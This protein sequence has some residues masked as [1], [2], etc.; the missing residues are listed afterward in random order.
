M[1]SQEGIIRAFEIIILIIRFF[2]LPEAHSI[3]DI[4]LKAKLIPNTAPTQANKVEVC[5][6]LNQGPIISSYR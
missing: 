6:K 1:K 3:F 2:I 5:V 4:F